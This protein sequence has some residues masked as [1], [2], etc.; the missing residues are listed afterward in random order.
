MRDPANRKR[1]IEQR[2]KAKGI[3]TEQATRDVD[4]GL[5]YDE[6]FRKKE[7]GTATGEEKAELARLKS[8]PVVTEVV[9]DARQFQKGAKVQEPAPKIGQSQNENQTISVAA[10]IDR[11]DNPNASQTPTLRDHH[12]AALAATATTGPLD[13]PAEPMRITTKMPA[14][15]QV[16]ATGMNF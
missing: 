11:L 16:A 4:M 9:T 8:N 5:R 7:M 2:A 1:L 3:T 13:V 10:R 15:E 6:L 14:S 12:R